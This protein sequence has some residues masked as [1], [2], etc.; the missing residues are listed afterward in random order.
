MK[1]SPT[2][3]SPRKRSETRDIVQPIIRALNRMPGVRVTRNANLGPVVPYNRRLE[4]DIRPIL[5]GLGT[6]SAD[7]VGVVTMRRLIVQWSVR[8]Y[9]DVDIAEDRGPVQ[10]VGRA[11][12]LEVKLPADPSKGLRAGTLHKDQKRWLSTVR[13]FG[14]F[15]AVVTSIEEA[16]AAVARCRTG[17]SE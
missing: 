1:L 3:R 4:P 5:A 13:R 12:V 11:F 2:P 7:V 8:E 10:D 17:E 14:G 16:V 9:I 15:A 6:G